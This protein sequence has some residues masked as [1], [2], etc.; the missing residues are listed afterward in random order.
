[1]KKILLP[2]LSIILL[3]TL[4][5]CGSKSAT[6]GADTS[7]DSSKKTARISFDFNDKSDK[8]YREHVTDLWNQTK[9]LWKEDASKNYTEEDYIARGKEIDEAWVNLQA[10]T[11]IATNGHDSQDTSDSILGNMTGKMIEETDKL[12]GERSEGDTKE[13]R[14][15]RRENAIKYLSE[16]IKEYD[17]KLSN[18]TIK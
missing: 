7:A 10:H 12:Y 9:V 5:A 18:L 3:L 16:T 2:L 4:T 13:K 6:T 15:E 14:I 17:D 1:M 11:S 8:T